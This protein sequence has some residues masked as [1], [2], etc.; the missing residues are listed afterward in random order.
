M[1]AFAETVHL[2]ERAMD[3]GFVASPH[4][5][6]VARPADTVR[7]SEAT[8]L[9]SR[10]GLFVLSAVRRAGNDSRQLVYRSGSTAIS[11]FASGRRFRVLSESD[12]WNHVALGYGRTGRMRK[13]K[14]GMV[15]LTWIHM[16][17]RCT[18]VA[19]MP[20][21]DLRGFVNRVVEMSAFPPQDS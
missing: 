17:R 18:A 6:E 10:V 2:R 3:P 19:A 5:L 14:D 15:A 21:A 20:S 16:G 1:A 8:G 11:V 12:G 9:P 13:L 7:A 4:P